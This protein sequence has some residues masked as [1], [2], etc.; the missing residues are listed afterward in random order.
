L[1]H[2]STMYH[3]HTY[4]SC[5]STVMV[6]K[7]RMKL[8]EDDDDS[9]KHTKLC[10]VFH[11]NTGNIL[12]IIQYITP[13]KHRIWQYMLLHCCCQQQPCIY[14]EKFL[15]EE[16]KMA[17]LHSYALSDLS[18]LELSDSGTDDNNLPTT[19]TCKNLQSCHLMYSRDSELC[20]YRHKWK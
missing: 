20:E 1:S 3:L 9:C 4:T 18:D 2:F 7:V 5:E 13:C 12:Y 10:M 19:C 17:E 14:V 16:E 11:Y 15:T 8:K 6:Q